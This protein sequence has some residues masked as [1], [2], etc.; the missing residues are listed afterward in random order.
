[1]GRIM[2]DHLPPQAR[3]DERRDDDRRGGAGQRVV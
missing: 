3:G 2:I 1:M